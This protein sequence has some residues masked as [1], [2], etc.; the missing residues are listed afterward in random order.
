VVTLGQSCAGIPCSVLAWNAPGRRLPEATAATLLGGSYPTLTF[1]IDPSLETPYSHQASAGVQRALGD[2]LSAAVDVV[3]VRGFKQVGTIDYNPVVPA[4]GTSR[5]PNDRPCSANPAAPCV[6]GGIPGSSASVLQYTSFG[7]TWYKGL[8]VSVR[9]RLA[10]NGQF[11]ASYTLSKAEDNSTDFQSNFI[12]ENNGRGRNPDD[13]S[14]LPLGFD[15][16]L[17]R[18]LAT[19]D[20]RHRMV[21]SGTYSLPGEVNVSAIV[22]AASGR[23]FTPLAGL[24][25]NGDGNGGAFPPDRA[26]RDP[27]DPSSSVG[28]NS[29]TTDGIANVDLRVSKALPLGGTAALELILDVFNVFNRANF[30]EDTNQSSF[31]IFGSGAYPTNALSTYGRYTLTEPPR[32]VQLAA[33]V[34]F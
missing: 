18:G 2:D 7:E 4:L 5:R 20:Q 21:L 25:L 29:E 22:T 24:D 6:G 32:Q 19:H 17:E 8:T 15:P 1:G 33:K 10:A 14:G 31:A 13:R 11:L 28:R 16:A 3:Y 23:P 26:R 34:R 9:G 27:A 12:P 30:I